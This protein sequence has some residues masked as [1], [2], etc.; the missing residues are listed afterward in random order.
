MENNFSEEVLGVKSSLTALLVL[1][2]LLCDK[3]TVVTA[4]SFFN[5]LLSY[6][7]VTLPVFISA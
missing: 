5:F 6:V 2:S 3:S 7:Y 1:F 4:F